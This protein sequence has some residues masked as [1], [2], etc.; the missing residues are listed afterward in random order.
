MQFGGIIEISFLKRDLGI[1]M[2]SIVLAIALIAIMLIV[3]CY[4]SETKAAR[5]LEKCIEQE[6]RID[7]LN[8]ELL[9]KSTDITNLTNRLK[10]Q[11]KQIDILNDIRNTLNNNLPMLDTAYVR[12]VKFKGCLCE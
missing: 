6:E 4:F 10:E 3:F 5:Y 8:L 1:N 2:I 12:N 9:G 7:E 11:Q